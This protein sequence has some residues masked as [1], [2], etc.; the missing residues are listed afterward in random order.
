ME[1]QVPEEFEVTLRNGL[2]IIQ[3]NRSSRKNAF[4]VQVL[5]Y[6]SIIE[7]LFLDAVSDEKCLYYI[8]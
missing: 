7:F 2:L 4:N 1:T 8:Y 6:V 5:Q 3:F